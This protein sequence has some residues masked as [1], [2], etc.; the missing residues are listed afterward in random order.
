MLG[1]DLFWISDYLRGLYAHHRGEGHE[2][3]PLVIHLRLRRGARG[4]VERTLQLAH[5]PLRVLDPFTDPALHGVAE[6]VYREVEVI[7]RPLT[8]R[9]TVDLGPVPFG[10][11]EETDGGLIGRPDHSPIR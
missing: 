1:D 8:D 6:A 9:F 10:V 4:A 7:A 2:P 11:G 3:R 5:E